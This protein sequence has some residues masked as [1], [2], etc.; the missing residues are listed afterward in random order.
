M[1]LGDIERGDFHEVGH[2]EQDVDLVHVL[3]L[4]EAEFG[5]QHAAM[6][7]IDTD[8]GLQPHDGREL[9]VAQLRFDHPH[10]V[11]GLIFVTFRVGVARHPE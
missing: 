1:K 4:I 7:G 2:A 11:V 9:A 5:G 6:H 3:L 8:L 10:Q